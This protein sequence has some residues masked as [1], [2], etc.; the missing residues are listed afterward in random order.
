[1]LLLRKRSRLQLGPHS[2]IT[3]SVAQNGHK[4]S[5]LNRKTSNQKKASSVQDEPSPHVCSTIWPFY[6]ITLAFRRFAMRDEGLERVDS[7]KLLFL[8]RLP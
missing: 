7:I 3:T 6:L 2:D 1:M 4:V 5:K 8:A